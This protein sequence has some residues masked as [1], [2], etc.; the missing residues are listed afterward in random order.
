MGKGCRRQMS[1][2]SEFRWPK[3]SA[4][5]YLLEALPAER[6]LDVF[7]DPETVALLR[8]CLRRLSAKHSKCATGIVK[9]V[10]AVLTLVPERLLKPLRQ[11]SCDVVREESRHD[12]LITGFAASVMRQARAVRGKLGGRGRLTLAR[13]RDRVEV[14][15]ARCRSQ[16]KYRSARRATVRAFD[17]LYDGLSRDELQAISRVFVGLDRHLKRLADERGIACLSTEANYRYEW[18]CQRLKLVLA[19]AM[20]GLATDLM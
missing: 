12:R 11:S 2:L 18:F 15:V 5:E 7:G 17:R 19:L 9:A 4:E 6:D 16:P 20:P 14:L 3:G 13:V 1:Y 10:R 8:R